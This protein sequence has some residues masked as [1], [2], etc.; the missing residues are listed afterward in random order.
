MVSVSTFVFLVVLILGVVGIAFG[1]RAK[2]FTSW[3]I[4]FWVAAWV[5]MLRAV[6]V[7]IVG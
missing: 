7:P 1:I 6:W 3:H 5:L 4:W 2:A